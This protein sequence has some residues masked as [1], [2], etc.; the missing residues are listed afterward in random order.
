[1]SFD[2]SQ[3]N[4]ASQQP[5]PIDPIEV[6]LG[7]AITDGNINDLWLGQGDALRE[8]NVHRDKNDV[9]VVLNTGAGKT[10]VGLL[11]G[12]QLRGFHP[13]V[14]GAWGPLCGPWAAVFLA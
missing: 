3:L 8:W 1:M 11:L 9:A 7:A 10:L 14:R 4:V 12:C 13:G 6:F 5:K 2:F